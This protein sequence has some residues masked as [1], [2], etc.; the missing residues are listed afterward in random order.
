MLRG[1]VQL[2][3]VWLFVM[4]TGMAPATLRA[5]IMFSM[6]VLGEMVSLRPNS[7]NTLAVSAFLMLCVNPNLLFDVGFQLSYTSV[8]GILL[9]YDPMKSFIRFPREET[10]RFWRSLSLLPL[11]FLGWLW[12]LVCLSTAAQLGSLPLV[13]FYFHQ[14][15]V[16][17]LIANVTVVP[18]AGLLL[19]T[20]LVVV[21]SSWIPMVADVSLSLLSA[22]LTATESLTRWVSGLPH[23]VVE[24]KMDVPMLLVGY[25]AVLLLVM[26]LRLRPKSITRSPM[27]TPQ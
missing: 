15:P 27:P 17:F 26:L 24:V 5:G 6:M 19:A 20:V 23:A 12:G 22:E 14:F 16:W 9:M 1:V 2:V 10:G 11:R 4:V 25:C 13:L 7:C 8:L 18:F 3:A 21:L